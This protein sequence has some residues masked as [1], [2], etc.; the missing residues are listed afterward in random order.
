MR[1]PKGRLQKSALVFWPKGYYFI[2]SRNLCRLP[3]R[4]IADTGADVLKS[5]M[6]DGKRET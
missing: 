2:P 3:V 5:E 6:A 4:R 1:A